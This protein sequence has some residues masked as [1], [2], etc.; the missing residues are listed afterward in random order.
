MCFVLSK[1]TP[2]HV[3]KIVVLN[4]FMYD[5]F[6]MPFLAGCGPLIYKWKKQWPGI[7]LLEAL[8]EHI[9][10]QTA[11]TIWSSWGSGLYM[12]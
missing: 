6:G 10:T 1:S 5:C 3:V 2:P 8:L 11:A 9:R 12:E 4:V 7:M